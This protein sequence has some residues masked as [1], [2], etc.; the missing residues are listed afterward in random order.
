M[1]PHAFLTFPY[2]TNC[3][4]GRGHG[5]EHGQASSHACGNT[6][7]QRCE[8]CESVGCLTCGGLA[9]NDERKVVLKMMTTLRVDGICCPAEVPLIRR[10]LE[11]LPGV[12]SVSVNVPAKQTRVEHD[13]RTSAQQLMF[14]LNDGGGLDAQIEKLTRIVKYLGSN[15][16]DDS[17]AARLAKVRTQ[18]AV[19]PHKLFLVKSWPASVVDAEG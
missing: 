19:R 9:G 1:G 12:T 3:T 15:A 18:L 6:D 16:G 5:H 2:E 10:L 11:P 13:C 8:F 7:C 17:S 14:A 4:H